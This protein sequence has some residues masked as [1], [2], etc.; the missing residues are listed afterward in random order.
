MMLNSNYKNLIIGVFLAVVCMLVLPY[1]IEY[2]TLSLLVIY[3]IL[4]LSLGLVWGFGGILCFGQAAFFGLGAYSYAVFAINIGESTLPFLLAIIVPATFAFILGAIMFYGRLTDVYLGVITLVVTLILF[5]FINSTASPE[6][7]IGTAHLGGFNGIPNFQTLNIPGMPD[8]HI[9]DLDFYYVC[10][11]ILMLS[12][13]GL[14]F[15]VR[16]SF[17]RV[18]IGIGQNEQRA[19]L[20]GYDVRKYKTILFAVGGGL[21][22]L[23]GALYASWAEIVTPGLF[24]LGQSAE[25]IIWCIVGGVTR[26]SGPIFGAVILGLLKYYLGQQTLIDNNLV[27]G[28]ILVTFVLFLPQGLAPAISSV[29]KKL[30]TA[31]KSTRNKLRKRAPRQMQ[32]GH[33]NE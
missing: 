20:I 8:A 10:F 3:S 7:M 28:V 21:A 22:G 26:L 4:A 33:L 19:E 9:W 23:A 16:S 27:F 15:L 1:F 24:S 5:R 32:R 12:Y 25:V 31:K 6:Y 29:W 17:G 14:H 2:Y 18:S 30:L 13:L 11:I